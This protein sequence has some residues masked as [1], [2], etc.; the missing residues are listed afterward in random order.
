MLSADWK[1]NAFEADS[2]GP[3][4]RKLYLWQDGP[5]GASSGWAFAVSCFDE[6][7]EEQPLWDTW[8]EEFERI[9]HYP[10]KYAPQDVVWRR[11]ESGETID[12][13]ALKN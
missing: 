3:P 4:K 9:L 8:E 7:G 2:P 6:A 13:Y 5:T 11:I 1:L 10:P 12:L